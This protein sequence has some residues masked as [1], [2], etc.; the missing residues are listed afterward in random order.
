MDH[1][2]MMRKAADYQAQALALIEHADLSDKA[3]LAEAANY[4]TL[5]AFLRE[6]VEARS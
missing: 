5:A 4:I 2:E 1:D 6:Y 3:S